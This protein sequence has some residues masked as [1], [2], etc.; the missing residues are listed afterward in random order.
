MRKFVACGLAFVMSAGVV[1]ATTTA[2][3]AAPGDL[4]TDIDGI[5]TDSRL[6]GA[7]I[8]V[9]VR[10]ARTGAVLYDRRAEDQE[11]PASNNKLETSTAAFGI[12]GPDYRFDTKVLRA[13]GNLYLK[14]TGDPTMRGAEYDALAAAVAAKGVKN[15]P[16]DLV[17]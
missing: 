7:S 9:I 17:A 16:G 14:G 11:T 5:L 6:D 8:G 4:K 15:V 13:N 10:D 1:V 2:A 3:G 12:L